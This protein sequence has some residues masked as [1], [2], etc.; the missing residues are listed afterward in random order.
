LEQL[1]MSDAVFTGRV[2]TVDVLEND[3]GHEV[4]RA[5]VAVREI[6]KGLENPKTLVDTTPVGSCSFTLMV[7]DEYLIYANAG[8]DAFWT[9][10]CKRTRHRQF[11]VEDLKDLGPPLVVL[12]NDISSWGKIKALYGDDS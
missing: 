4:R 6:W 5:T 11:A 3:T 1:A 7:G 10:E 9:H 2:I 8:D 12:D